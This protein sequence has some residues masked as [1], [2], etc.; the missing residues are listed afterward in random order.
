MGLTFF[1]LSLDYRLYLFNQIHDIVFHGG[2]GYDYDTIYN[3]PIW[4][5]KFTFSKLK[6][7]HQ[8]KENDVVA[9]SQ[10]A[11]KAA[12]ADNTTPKINVPSYVTKASRK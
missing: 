1:G 7:Y 6:E 4:L 8:P 5:R 9:Q 2:G 11:M 12:Q 3:M 10:Q